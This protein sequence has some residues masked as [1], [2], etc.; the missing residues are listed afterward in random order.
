MHQSNF[1]M[2]DDLGPSRRLAVPRVTGEEDVPTA[3][4]PVLGNDATV[5]NPQGRSAA[6]SRRRGSDRITLRSDVRLGT[7]NVQTLHQQGKLCNV[8]REMRNCGLHLLGVTETHWTG[9]GHFTTETGEL[10]VYSGGDA[11]RAGVGVIFSKVVANSMISYRPVNDRILY[12]R[13]KASP[14]NISLLQIYAPTTDA[15]EEEV[16]AFYGQLQEFLDNCPRQDVLVIGGDFNG[17][18]E[19]NSPDSCVCGRFGLGNSNS[20]G[21]RLIEFCY[22][23]DLFITNT[24]FQHHTR[25]R[26]TWMSPGGRCRNQI[27]FILI[28]KR[29]LRCVTNSRAYP[30]ADCG[31]DH[32]LVAATL[33]LRIRRPKALSVGV[34]LNPRALDDPLLQEVYNVEVNNRFEELRLLEDDKPPEEMFKKVKDT[35]TAT[36]ESILGKAPR[37]SKQPWISEETQQL[38]DRRKEL[39]INR[40][41]V[42]GDIRYRMAHREGGTESGEEG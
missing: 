31:S 4:N 28:K 2:D 33:K 5:P 10:V 34:R 35:V 3:S 29:W 38:M 20:A 26:Y 22:D 19:G 27:D 40:S 32:N 30:G 25:R 41:N 23:N 14:F 11:H 16:E 1:V 39:K 24:A 15:D 37:R 36:A 9:N 12:V 6:D 21:E 8:T 18:V 42:D 17:K 7:W 13:I